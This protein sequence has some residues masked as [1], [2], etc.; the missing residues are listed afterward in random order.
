VSVETDGVLRFEDADVAAGSRHGYRL[1]LAGETGA[2]V[3]GETWVEVPVGVGFGIT[4]LW[5]N[6]SRGATQV[7]FDLQGN[8]V[9]ALEIYDA[10]GRRLAGL[11]LASARRGRHVRWLDTTAGLPSGVYWVRLRDG[12]QVSSARLVVTR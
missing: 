9:A 1:L 3:A 6:P 8:A 2:F 10:S 4:R 7:Q 12:A 5:P 11:P